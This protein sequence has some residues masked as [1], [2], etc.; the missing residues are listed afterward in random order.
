MN[1]SNHGDFLTF[2]LL[3]AS[4]DF[5]LWYASIPW[6]IVYI[7]IIRKIPHYFDF[8]NKTFV[9]V[10]ISCD[11]D[12]ILKRGEGLPMKKYW[13][14]FCSHILICFSALEWPLFVIILFLFKGSAFFDVMAKIQCVIIVF[15]CVAWVILMPILF[16]Q[17]LC[18]FDPQKLTYRSYP[19]LK[20]RRCKSRKEY[21][22]KYITFIISCFLGGPVIILS[23]CGLCYGIIMRFM[24]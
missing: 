16:L 2:P 17:S 14:G 13:A 12:E 6:A 11:P 19:M 5:P 22:F 10:H 1:I 20:V 21:C 23:L 24:T 3:L 4:T 9:P 18:D 8:R 7:I 15:T